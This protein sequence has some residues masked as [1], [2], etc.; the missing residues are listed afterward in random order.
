MVTL[1][2]A[3]ELRVGTTLHNT[4]LYNADGTPMRA[5]VTG[6]VKTWKKDPNKIKVPLKHGM[7]DYGYLTEDNTNEWSLIAGKS[8]VKRR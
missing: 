3:K 6:K 2:E 7:Y 8:R 1:K 4:K 5:R